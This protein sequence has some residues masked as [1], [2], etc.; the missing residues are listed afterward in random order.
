MLDTRRKK[1]VA[2]D[3]VVKGIAVVDVEKETVVGAV[4][5]TTGVVEVEVAVEVKFSIIN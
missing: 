4:E 3:L 5:A 2:A 1:G